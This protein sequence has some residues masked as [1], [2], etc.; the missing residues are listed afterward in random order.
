MLGLTLSRFPGVTGARWSP[1]DSRLSTFDHNLILFLP[2]LSG[3]DLR[4]ETTSCRVVRVALGLFFSAS[5][6][7]A[8]GPFPVT[9]EHN[10]SLKLHDGITL[11]ADIYRPQA[12][13]QF[14]VLLSGLPMT[15]AW[16]P[17]SA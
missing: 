3:E 16:E 1:L 9:F 12:E 11:R 5:A 10:V 7:R 17:R 8:A 6:A 4:H 14:P 15:K 13:G 2:F